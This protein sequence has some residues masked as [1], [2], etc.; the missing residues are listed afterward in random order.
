MK[1]GVWGGRPLERGKSLETEK[2]NVANQNRVSDAA[3]H[4]SGVYSPSLLIRGMVRVSSRHRR[5]K[6]ADRMLSCRYS[7]TVKGVIC[8]IPSLLLSCSVISGKEHC[9]FTRLDPAIVS[10]GRN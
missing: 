10:L 8:V 7:N 3:A 5:L 2:H 4:K 9:S 6:E 1:M